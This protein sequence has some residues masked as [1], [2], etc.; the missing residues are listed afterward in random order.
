GEAIDPSVAVES[1][2][3]ARRQL[4]AIARALSRRMRILVLDEPTAPLTLLEAD[5]LFRV[6]RRLRGEGVGVVHI[7]HRL[8]EVFALA[9]RITV[10]RDGRR[11]LT[12]RAE[13][14]DR[15]A[16]IRSM[17]GRELEGEYPESRSEPGDPLLEVEGL[18][19]GRVG[20][21]SFTLRRGEV[22]GI[23]G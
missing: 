5:R 13:E 14:I 10:L 17:V 16:L 7:S 21:V 8:D 4:V 18:A 3:V 22:V 12:A 11:T 23:A 9:D 15:N 19:S 6:V 1:L 20:P 2:D